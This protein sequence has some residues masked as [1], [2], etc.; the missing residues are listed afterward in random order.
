MPIRMRCANLALAPM[1][2]V[3]RSVHRANLLCFF[4]STMPFIRTG[5]WISLNTRG[6]EESG[7]RVAH[8]IGKRVA[9]SV[10][11]RIR[12][13][14]VYYACVSRIERKRVSKTIHIHIQEVL[15][16]EVGNEVQVINVGLLSLKHSS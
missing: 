11:L 7:I 2:I 5:C 4:S 16:S 8:A 9:A 12:T 10:K 6:A 1:G 3:W 13:E 15:C 14:R